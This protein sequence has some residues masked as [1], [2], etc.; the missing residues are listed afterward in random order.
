MISPEELRAAERDLERQ[1]RLVEQQR[2]QQ[3]AAKAAQEQKQQEEQRTQRLTTGR[4]EGR[5]AFNPD[6]SPKP[7]KPVE[8]ITQAAMDAEVSKPDRERGFISQAGDFINQGILQGGVVKD[9]ANALAAGLNQITPEGSPVKGLTQGLDDFVMSQEEINE[10]T[11]AQIEDRRE[12][13][14]GIRSEVMAS[15][16][17][18]DAGTRAGLAGQMIQHVSAG[19]SNG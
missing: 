5:A 10:S 17:G 7:G 18:V 16:L 12:Q 11:A 8:N 2:Q 14:Q 6:D 15:L 19:S 1:R 9:S 13:G 3:E 4:G